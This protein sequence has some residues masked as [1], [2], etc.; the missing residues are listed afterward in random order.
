MQFNAVTGAE[1]GSAI[2]SFTVDGPDSDQWSVVYSA[3][4]E[5]EQTASFPSHMVTVTGLTVGKEYTFR[6]I[7]DTDLYVTGT[8]EIKFVAADLVYAENLIVTSCIDN[9]L[10]AQWDTP[11]G[12]TVE[13]WTVRCY[14]D[15]YNETI[16]TAENTAVFDELDHTKAYTVEVTAAAMSVNQRVNVPENSVTISNLVVDAT[17]FSALQLTWDASKDVPKDGWHLTYTIDGSELQSTILCDDNSA[18][19]PYQVPGSVYEITIRDASGMVAL[20][21][22]YTYN[23]PAETTF[24]CDYSGYSVSSE[25]MSF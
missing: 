24:T 2:L 23:V 9:T 21:T 18:T 16:I 8:E 5:E 1:N 10:I 7:P 6:L 13:T 12:A 14:N 19:I 20:G 17:D 22:P 15:D 3:E 25:D 11:D 4:G